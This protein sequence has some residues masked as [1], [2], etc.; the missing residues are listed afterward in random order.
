MTENAAMEITI[1]GMTCDSCAVHVRCAK[2]S[3]ACPACAADQLFPYLTTVEGIKFA[4]QTF[5]KDVKQL[6]CCVG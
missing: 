4:A 6:S 5:T 1:T 2:R 3:K